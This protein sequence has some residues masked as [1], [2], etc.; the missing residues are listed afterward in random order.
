FDLSANIPAWH[1]MILRAY[2]LDPDFGGSTLDEFLLLYYASVP[3]MLGGDPELARKHFDLAMEKS[4]GGSTGALISYA[5]SISVPEQDYERF[6]DLLERA[7]AVDP[8][9]NPENRLVIILDQRRARW[10]LE[11][12]RDFFAFLP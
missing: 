4:G 10:L 3:E 5:R 7:L 1:Q 11:N 6:R 8:N 12:A 9:D 2:E